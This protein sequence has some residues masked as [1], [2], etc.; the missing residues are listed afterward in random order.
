N[1]LY[2]LKIKKYDEFFYTGFYLNDSYYYMPEDDA[3]KVKSELLC[4]STLMKICLHDLDR[5]YHDELREMGKKFVNRDFEGLDKYGLTEDMIKDNESL[6][7]KIKVM[8]HY[9]Q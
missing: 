5:F 8:E 3:S 2:I 1:K 9:L 6:E 7:E 4:D